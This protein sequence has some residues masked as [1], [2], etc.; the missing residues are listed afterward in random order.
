[1]G[2]LLSVGPGRPFF[3]LA[4]GL[5]VVSQCGYLHIFLVMYFVPRCPFSLDLFKCELSV[6][7]LRVGLFE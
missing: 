4:L 7:P 3:L 2:L 5:D 6:I 1:M